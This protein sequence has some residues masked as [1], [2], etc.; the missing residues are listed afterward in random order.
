MASKQD[1][2]ALLNTELRD[3]DNFTFTELE[4]EHAVERAIADEDVYYID[5]ERITITSVTP[6]YSLDSDIKAVFNV[7]IDNGDGFPT[8]LNAEAWSH[9]AGRGKLLIN[10]AYKNIPAGQT[11]VLEV[12]RKLDE[13]DDIPAPL[14]EFVLALAV[15]RTVDLLSNSKVN[16]FL[17]N[18]TTMGEIVAKRNNAERV[19]YDWRKKLR[20]NIAVGLG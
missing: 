1:L 17:K 20:H 15:V 3:S 8:D 19:V 14:S 7:G 4:K 9:A 13:D 11:L 6:S 10:R 18:D 12:A 16:R 5:E 2:I